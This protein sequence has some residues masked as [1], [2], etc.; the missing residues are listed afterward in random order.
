MINAM[1]AAMMGVYQNDFWIEMGQL[2][3]F[4][5]PF[6]LLGLLLRKPL[7]R[8]LNWYVGKVEDSKLV[9]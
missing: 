4:V 2:M 9:A 5:I 6:A 8:F 3:L 1:R 7:I